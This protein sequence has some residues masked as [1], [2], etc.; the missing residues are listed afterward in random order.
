[1]AIEDV[2]QLVEKQARQKDMIQGHLGQLTR[3]KS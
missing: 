2:G 1:V 3:P